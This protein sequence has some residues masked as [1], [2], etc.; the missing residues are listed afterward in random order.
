MKKDET[1]IQDKIIAKLKEHK[2]LHWRMSGA[3]NLSG[4]PDLLVCYK[5]FFVGLE[6]KTPEGAPTL[7][8]AKVIQDIIQ[9]GGVAGLVTSI[10]DVEA[11]LRGIDEWYKKVSGK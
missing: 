6:V 1:L 11:L 2:I 8:Q 7:Q 9:A 3:S 4:F 5:G 10:E